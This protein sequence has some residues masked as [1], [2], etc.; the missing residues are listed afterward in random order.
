MWSGPLLPFYS[1]FQFFSSIFRLF[2][3]HDLFA[4]PSTF[5][6]FHLRP[7][8]IVVESLS[9]VLLFATPWTIARQASLSFTISPSLLK[10]M[11]IE[12]VMPSSH[13]VLCHPLLLLPFIF[14]SIRVF[15]SELAFHIRWPK[16]WSLSFS[17]TI[18]PSN[19][20][21]ISFKI[22]LFDLLAVQGT[23]KSFP[24]A[25]FRKHQFFSPQPSFWFSSHIHMW[26]LGRL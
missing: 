16:Y 6:S 2:Q 20:G 3:P 1:H 18:S 19:S 5:P 17:F 21:L 24:S 8:I 12:L 26:L 11:S 22:D 15:S 4:V 7:I 13:L 25:I 23:L 14:S 9:C 10:L